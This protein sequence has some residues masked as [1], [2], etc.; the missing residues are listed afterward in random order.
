MVDDDAQTPGDTDLLSRFDLGPP[1]HFLLPA[2]LLLLAEEP[3]HGYRLVER[4]RSLRFGTVDR[5]N[6]Y[7]AL[8]QLEA[9]GLV[10]VTRQ[11]TAGRERREYALTDH[12]RHAL[13]TWMGVVKEDRDCLDRVMRRYAALSSADAVLAEV[14]GGSR[15]MT[16]PA[17]SAVSLTS[18]IEGHLGLVRG[19][20]NGDREP[21]SD[22]RLETGRHRF[23]V[24]PGRSAVLIEA[25]STVGPISFGAID[26]TGWVECDLRDGKVAAESSPAAE[27]DV[28]IEHLRSGNQLYDAE[29][30]RRLDAR[31]YPTV[32]LALRGCVPLASPD[33]FRVRGVVLLH[34]ATKELEGTVV[35]T[36]RSDGN[37]VVAGEQMIDI[38]DFNITSPTVLMLRI[39]PDVMVSLQLEAELES[40][41]AQ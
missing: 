24:L 11:E 17:W 3:D 7:R 19:A 32:R 25:R 10:E 14:V 5:P 20:P 26:V 31:R 21:P 16:G 9:D 8:G 13:R 28:P 1:R 23:L 33:R 36:R 41:S 18:E 22:Q 12:G 37:L 29:L 27:L 30:L 2:L 4:A 6:V 40:K 35:V 15:T 39:Y 38:R 34:G